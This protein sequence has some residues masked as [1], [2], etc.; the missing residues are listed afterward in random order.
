MTDEPQLPRLRSLPIEQRLEAIARVVGLSDADVT[1]ARAE[2][3]LEQPDVRQH[4]I[5][6]EYACAHRR[7]V[8]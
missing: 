7:T 8:N 1:A 4:I 3:G 5:D 2:L 6:D